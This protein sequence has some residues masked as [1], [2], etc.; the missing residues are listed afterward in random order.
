[1]FKIK[2]NWINYCGKSRTME[3]LVRFIDT[4]V[5]RINRGSLV[6]AKRYNRMHFLLSPND[7][8]EMLGVL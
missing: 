6:C 7:D 1:M 3:Y 2:P 5:P 4:E 8:P